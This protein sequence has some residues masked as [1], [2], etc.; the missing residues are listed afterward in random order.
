MRPVQ[1]E[2]SGFNWQSFSCPCAM[3]VDLEELA[4][5]LHVI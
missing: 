2:H 4:V 1:A 3:V 5:L